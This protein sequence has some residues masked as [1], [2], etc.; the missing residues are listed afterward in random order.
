MV[1]YRVGIRA[2][3]VE[4]RWGGG[5]EFGAGGA[6]EFF[7]E[8]EGIG[9]AA[10]EAG[11][12]LG[13]FFAQGGVDGVVEFGGVEG[14]ADG[15]EG[16]HLVVFLRD[17]VVA[18]AFFFL[19]I[20][21][22]RDVDEDVAEHADGVSVASHHHVAEADVVVGCE[23]RG[24]DAREHGFFVQLDVIQGF[25]REGEIAEEAVDPE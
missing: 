8:G 17:A 25:E 7:E 10:L 18:G 16:V 13:V 9:P 6:E 15:D 20:L 12:L 14:D 3:G 5:D 4:V 22:P 19:E 11:E 24:H 21:C 23:V 1:V 2:G